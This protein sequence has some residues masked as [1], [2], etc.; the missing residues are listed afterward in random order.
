MKPT[1]LLILD[2]HV[3]FREGLRRLLISEPD[4]ETVAECGS[5]A[6]AL[7]Y[8]SRAPVDVILLDFDLDNET[9]NRFTAAAIAAGYQG[10]ILMVTAGMSALDLSVARRLGVSGIFL[11]HDSPRA[12]L[13]AIRSVAAGQDWA[14]ETLARSPAAPLGGASRPGTS[15]AGARTIE[16]LTPREQQVLRKVFEGLTNKEISH[17]VGASLSA[18]KATLQSLFEKTGVRTRSQLVRI[19][20][21]RSLETARKS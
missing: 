19:A 6:E 16:G 10:R 12:L 18:V 5:P 1:R 3:L 20:I 7:E 8:V 21:E 17:Q 4:F 2:D 14:G 13:N 9:G 15:R 11:K